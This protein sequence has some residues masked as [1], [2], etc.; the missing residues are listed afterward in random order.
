MGGLDRPSIGIQMLRAFTVRWRH[1]LQERYAL[2]LCRNQGGRVLDLGAGVGG[3]ELHGLEMIGASPAEL[4]CFRSR[5]NALENQPGNGKSTSCIA[6]T[7]LTIASSLDGKPWCSTI[8]SKST[9]VVLPSM[10]VPS[11]QVM[12]LVDGLM[13]HDGK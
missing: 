5:G 13:I 7:H 4:F 10:V 2:D 9:V 6:R 11:S 12:R 8:I 1:R 3:S